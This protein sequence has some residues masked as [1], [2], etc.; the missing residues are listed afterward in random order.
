MKETI[1]FYKHRLTNKIWVELPKM[2][3]KRCHVHKH[4]T[5]LQFIQTDKVQTKETNA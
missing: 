5:N 4:M 1:N 3:F 2:T